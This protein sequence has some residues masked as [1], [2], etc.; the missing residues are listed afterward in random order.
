MHW[1]EWHN[2]HLIKHWTAADKHHFSQVVGSLIIVGNCGVSTV[3]W[4]SERWLCTLALKNAVQ[5]R[6]KHEL[7]RVA[8]RNSDTFRITG[9][10]WSLI[11]EFFIL[12]FRICHVISHLFISLSSHNQCC[13]LCVHKNMCVY[14]IWKI[15]IIYIY[16]YHIKIYI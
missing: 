15:F 1:R 16:I 14:Q 3:N 4:S 13:L 7:L 9:V 11:V 2:G 6:I 5:K 12:C 8:R 10:L